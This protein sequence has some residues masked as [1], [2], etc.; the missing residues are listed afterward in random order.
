LA[1]TDGVVSFIL[2][3]MEHSRG[4][5]D[6]A[7]REAQ[8]QGVAP[9]NPVRHAHGL[10]ARE[11]LA[12]LASRMFGIK[13][14]AEKIPVEGITKI[15][16]E[17]VEIAKENNFCVRVLGIVEKKENHLQAWIGPC[18]IPDR[19][20]LAQVRGG[21]EAAYLQFKDRTSMVYVGPGTSKEVVVRGMLRDLDQFQKQG[22][23]G[24]P[25]FREISCIP[26]DQQSASFYVRISIME[27]V[28][29]VARIMNI[30]AER[31]VKIQ[32]FYQR[33]SLKF[34]DVREVDA[35]DFVIFSKP[36]QEGVVRKVVD[37]I[38]S[39]VKLA[40]V[41]SCIRVEGN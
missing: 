33:P 34:S 10:V 38:R 14:P 7:L 39:E 17:D 12:L 5:V 32:S 9:G 30:F 1:V 26:L 21:M 15:S 20:L 41:K 6:D 19:Y 35:S 25:P 31:N 28:S 22:D 2:S 16:W 18:L 8:W 37:E 27:F 11:R 13:L 24:N 29:T 4:T 40:N 36:V 3:E 23:F